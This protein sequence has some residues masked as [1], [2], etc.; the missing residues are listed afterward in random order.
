MPLLDILSNIAAE[1]GVRI[2]DDVERAWLVSQINA[3]AKDFYSV[4]DLHGCEREQIVSQAANQQQIALPYYVQKVIAVRDYPTR[5]PLTQE[6]SRPRYLR[7]LWLRPFMGYPYFRWRI[8][9]ENSAIQN[10]I[11]NAAY[12]TISIPTANSTLFSVVITGST[13]SADKAQEI[14]TFPV[15]TTTLNTSQLWQSIDSIR[16]SAATDSNVTIAD[17]D[18]EVLA[19]IP[20]NELLSQ[21]M[22]VQVLD[23]MEY[24]QEDGLTEILYKTRF[25]NMVNDYDGLPCGDSYDQAIFF[26]T[27]ARIYGLRGTFDKSSVFSDKAE[28]LAA[29]ITMNKEGPIDK[30]IQFGTQK[31]FET[32]TK[33][34][35]SYVNGNIRV[36]NTGRIDR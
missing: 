8:K 5:Y 10:D 2:N 14:V 7:N 29:L 20:N 4:W 1:L 24:R 36:L 34:G 18:G 25:N 16:K 33:L 28:S 35:M 6:D 30:R 19:V 31:T 12:L 27:L 3:T 9:S 15:G 21:Y 32:F 17:L 23:R 22:V 26:K 11:K 13:T